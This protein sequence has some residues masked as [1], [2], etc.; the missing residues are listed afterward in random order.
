M[1][2]PERLLSQ[3]KA[4]VGELG[5]ALDA[6]VNV[7]LWNG[8]VVPLC[9]QPSSELAIRICDPG[10]VASLLRSPRMMTVVALFASGRLRIVNG[11]LLDFEPRRQD[12]E[13][14]VRAGAWRRIDTWRALKA[15]ASFLTLPGGAKAGDHAFEE[16]G[17]RRDDK[18]L[19][20]FHYDISNEFC[21]LFLDPL[22]VYSC[23]YFPDW[24]ASLEDAQTFKLDM[25]CRKLRLAPGEKLL[26]IGCGWGGLII[27]AARRYG[28]TAHGATLS[29]SQFAFA[30]A[31][32][33]ALGLQDRVTVT[34]ADFRSLDGV[35]DKIASVGMYEHIGA[36]N[37]DGYFAKVASLLR[38]RGL[39]LHHAIVRRA[40]PERRYARQV[41][42]RAM[43]KYIFP[44]GYLDHLGGSIAHLEMNEFDVHDVEGLREH[45]A[46]TCRKWTERLYARRDEASAM[47]G[48][49]RT[50]L[51][52]LYLARSA[53]AFDR[54]A[55]AVFQT[56]ASKRAPGASGLPPTRAD[57]HLPE[58]G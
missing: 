6:D 39:F 51:W 12:I 32:I 42:T 54:G 35:F 3:F 7:E 10:V 36:K 15:L 37:L 18:A 43:T 4:F 48:E 19:V 56:L 40:R 29:A 38:T 9:R 46:F 8:D 57:L 47:I 17:G 21:A 52:L 33:A 34:L 45:Y 11:T 53:I 58:R 31:R 20:Q 2:E 44:G 13:A 5:V 22:M 27:H 16:G 24:D 30:Q 28:V 50:H 1:P 41:T 26:D 55:A 23:A 25:I 14:K 49:V